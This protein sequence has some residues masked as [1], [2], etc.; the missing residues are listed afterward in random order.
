MA[1]QAELRRD[2]GAR[3]ER[4]VDVGAPLDERAQVTVHRVGGAALERDGVAGEEGRTRLWLQ[5]ADRGLRP[6]GAGEPDHGPCPA[7]RRGREEGDTIR[8]RAADREAVHPAT[9]D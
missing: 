9:A 2:D 5:D 7:P 4:P 8:P 1:P 3:A 6:P